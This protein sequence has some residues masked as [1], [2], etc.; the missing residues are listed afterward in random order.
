MATMG[1]ELTN[2]LRFLGSE[3]F[4]WLVVTVAVFG[5]LLYAYMDNVIPLIALFVIV[6]CLGILATVAAAMATGESEQFM[7]ELLK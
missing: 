4:A 3:T 2:T 1:N 7:R 5:S 6:L